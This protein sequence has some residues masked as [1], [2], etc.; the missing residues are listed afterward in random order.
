MLF[1]NH[2]VVF[3][4]DSVRSPFPLPTPAQCAPHDF[5]ITCPSPSLAP[6]RAPLF[7]PILPFSPADSRHFPR[8][9]HRAFVLGVSPPVLPDD[10]A[11]C[12]AFKFAPPCLVRKPMERGELPYRNRNEPPYVGVFFFPH[13]IC[14]LKLWYNTRRRHE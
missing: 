1:Q 7:L 10:W 11:G 13:F 4:S 14:P 5:P 8:V 12:P 2:R 3:P 9:P 6:P